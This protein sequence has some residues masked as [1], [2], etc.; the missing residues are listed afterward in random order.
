[1]TVVLD[2]PRDPRAQLMIRTGTLSLRRVCDFFGFEYDA[3][4]EPTD[5]ISITRAEFDH[6]LAQFDAI[7]VPLVADRDQAW[8]DYSGWRV[9][10]DRPLVSLAG[11][12]D[13]PS[14]PWATDRPVEV[15]PP[16][17]F[18]RRRRP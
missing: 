13:A 11:F 9:N 6:A 5:P 14:T 4:P 2:T 12:V 17:L 8:R 18:H 7:G 3:T 16:T 1:M 10:Y 15:N